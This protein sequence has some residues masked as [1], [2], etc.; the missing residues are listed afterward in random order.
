MKSFTGLGAKASRQER[1]GVFEELKEAC[2]LEH[3]E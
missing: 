1:A 3:T 2:W